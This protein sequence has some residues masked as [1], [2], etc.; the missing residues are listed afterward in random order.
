MT[1]P[2]LLSCFERKSF[3]GSSLSAVHNDNC[4]E[5]VVM[6]LLFSFT[7]KVYIN[8]FKL[9]EKKLQKRHFDSSS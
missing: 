6:R 5:N 9:W 7:K 2:L 8:P 4:L 1:K 3:S